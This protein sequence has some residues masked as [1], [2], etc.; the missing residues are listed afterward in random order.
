MLKG[1]WPFCVFSVVFEIVCPVLLKPELQE[2]QATVGRRLDHVTAETE[3]KLNDPQL[4]DLEE[5]LEQ[6][7]E[8]LLGCR[9][10]SGG[11]G[12]PREDGPHGQDMR[13]WSGSSVYMTVANKM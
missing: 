8:T 6:R 4:P 10:S 3:A 9:G 7:K 5:Q 13:E 11:D 12:A 2:V 1:I